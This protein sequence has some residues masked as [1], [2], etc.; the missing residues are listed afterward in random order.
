MY[1]R[2][3]QSMYYKQ[4]KKNCSDYKKTVDLG[5]GSG[6]KRILITFHDPCQDIWAESPATTSLSHGFGSSIVSEDSVVRDEKEMYHIDYIVW[7]IFI[8]NQLKMQSVR[9]L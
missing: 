4:N 9:N 2:A 6:G 7:H 8:R 5:K 1:T 3:T